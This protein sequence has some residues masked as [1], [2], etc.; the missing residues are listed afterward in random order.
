MK[1]YFK[2]F[3]CRTN[4]YDTE[5]LKSYVKNYEIVN[6]DNIADIIVVNSCTVTN[7]ADSGVRNYIN[8]M[9]NSG[10]KVILT[11]CGAV[12][13]GDEL[14]KSSAIF[15]VLGASNKSKIDEMLGKSEP[16][17]ELGDL[18]FIDKNIVS[19]YENHTKAFIK[20]QEGC[21]FAC[22]Y[23]IIPS[24]R[25]F[26]RSIDENII[27]KEAKILASNGYSEIVLTGTNI[28]SYGKGNNTTL[29]KLVANLG[30]INGI[31]RIRLG[32]IEPSQIDDSF[33]EILSEPWLERH[34]HIALQHTSQEMLTIMNRRNRA[35]RDLDLFCELSSMGFA[36]GT[37]FIVAHPGESKK[38]WSE[39]VENFIK[40]PLT[41]IHAFIFSPRNGTKSASMSID[42]SPQIAKERL[43]TL[44]N[45]V[46]Q[47]NIKF[48]QNNAHKPLEVLV[49]KSC[50]DDIYEGWDQ[51]YNKIKIKSSKNI[52]KEWINI[53]NYDIM[54]EFNYAQI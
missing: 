21:D 41:H 15:G 47:N 46:S 23:C 9:R 40:F 17:Y 35:L 25:G 54:Q 29:G 24:V 8:S 28:G 39:A 19:N 43:K 42:V 49:E 38:I 34:L 12:S 44:Q 5:L 11:G 26:S 3:G 36:L 37:D 33:R 31:K 53:T 48:R 4:I 2:T 51:Y 1:V 45:I 10:K 30:K 27:L 6:D 14:F 7:G 16:F 32:S 18:N 13:K 20:I 52:S 22:S 50:G